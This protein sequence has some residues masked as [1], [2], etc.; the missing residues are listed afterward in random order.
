MYR[1]LNKNIIAKA[2]LCLCLSFFIITNLVFAE[3]Y[4]RV[5]GVTNP[6]EFIED[7]N[8]RDASSN[9]RQMVFAEVIGVFDRDENRNINP[10]KVMTNLDMMKAL[11]DLSD[12]DF[13]KDRN[14]ADQEYR[15]KAIGLDFISQEELRKPENNNYFE[16]NAIARDFYKNLSK[17]IG[18][19]VRYNQNT[20]STITK[21]DIA[22]ALY[23]NKEII[24]QDRDLK[25]LSGVSLSQ[26]DFAEG[27]VL[28]KE[29]SVKLDRIYK[30]PPAPNNTG[31]HSVGVKNDEEVDSSFINIVSNNDIAILT[32]NGFT[33]DIKNIELATK[34]NIYME[35]GQVKYIEQFHVPKSRLMGV[36]KDWSITNYTDN[37]KEKEFTIEDENKENKNFT[38][39]IEI[40]DYNGLSQKYKVHPNVSITQ[41]VGEIG[42]GG[43]EKPVA[44]NQLSFGQDVEITMLNNIV[45]GIRAYVP[46]EEELN[47]YI[48]PQSRLVSGVVLDFGKDFVTLSDSKKYDI[49]P[50]TI[51]MKNSVM[52]DYRS[53]KDGD[54]AKLYFDDIYSSSP[55]KIEI[56]GSQRQVANIIKARVG[57]YSNIK[58]SLSLKN[59]SKFE[60]GTW[61]SAKNLNQDI[62]KNPNKY[63]NTSYINSANNG[64]NSG[65]LKSYENYKLLGNVYANSARVSNKNLKNFKDQ[66]IYAILSGNQG[67]PT[68]KKASIRLGNGLSY[69]NT[70]KNI[71][72]SQKTMEVDGNI[73]TFDDS[74]IIIKDGNLVATGNLE[75]NLY[76]SVE[77]DA[78]KKA[79]LI[80]QD[81]SI[82]NVTKKDSFPYKIYRATIRDVFEDSILLGND[83]EKDKKVNHY[84]MMQGG[85]WNRFS[86]TATTPRLR[87][88]DN[89]FFYDFDNKKQITIEEMR[90]QQYKFNAFG[91][92]PDYFNR[93]VYAITKDDVLVGLIYHKNEGYVQVNSQNMITAKA[94]AGYLPQENKEG[95]KGGNQGGKQGENKENN[96]MKNLLIRNISEY[97]SMTNTLIP[98]KPIVTT[99]EKTQQAIKTPVRKLLNIDKALVIDNGRVVPKTSIDQ[100]QG[101][102]I[103]VLF[104]QDRSKS[105]DKQGDMEVINAIVVI[106]N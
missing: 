47:S 37:Q 77:T 58:K 27:D 97:N 42:I 93:Q 104:K 22:Q 74:T 35:N 11:V 81:S 34:M 69:R 38:S 8:L 5:R 57:S 96:P 73:I 53:M 103:T 90:D 45:T 99:D 105:M 23:D 51:I 63:P 54:I 46:V 66:E 56:E 62:T 17:I 83:I 19:E 88:T 6:K 82:Y 30:I 9:M 32:P 16:R 106:A 48:P 68:I 36:L 72:H 4:H 86:E 100:L 21:L 75:P 92:R 13:K 101:K 10:K 15:Q 52:T 84:F 76:T 60:D 28:K 12:K 61:I 59:V 87:Y 20:S 91:T 1:V 64:R 41:V 29:V 102:F 2:F 55:S 43:Q 26:N 89:T 67:I 65:N 18:K 95:N 7:Y 3:K 31:V 78:L 79:S 14:P 80:V 24:L 33:T 71:D 85:V 49:S 70:L 25:L 50:E 94:V 44:E 98:L 40:V 39:T